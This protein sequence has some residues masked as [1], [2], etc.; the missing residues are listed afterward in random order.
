[1]SHGRHFSADTVGQP[2]QPDQIRFNAMRRSE[3][4]AQADR[5]R[6]RWMTRAGYKLVLKWFTRTVGV[7]NK[8]PPL[9]GAASLVLCR[10]RSQRP[11]ASSLSRRTM[12][13][14]FRMSA[15][16]KSEPIVEATARNRAL[17]SR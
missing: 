11:F 10:S 6:A 5:A 16:L 7:G 3:P 4:R 1:M 12:S 14:V 13:V 8:A 17:N 9:T 2:L 15:S